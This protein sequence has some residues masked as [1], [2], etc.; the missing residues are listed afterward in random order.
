MA[1]NNTCI[2]MMS[3]ISGKVRYAGLNQMCGAVSRTFLWQ[4][5]VPLPVLLVLD[6]LIAVT[7][8][9]RSFLDRASQTLA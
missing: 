5:C 8:I 1:A 7:Y 9:L 2:E 4:L 3:Y 6:P